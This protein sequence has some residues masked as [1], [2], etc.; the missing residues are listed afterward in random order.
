MEITLVVALI[1]LIGVLVGALINSR[2]TLGRDNRIKRENF[3]SRMCELKSLAGKIENANFPV[4]FAKC[5]V[6]VEKEC[7]LV[8]S[9]ICLRHRKRFV[10]ARKKCAEPQSEN[11]IADPPLPYMEHGVVKSPF[12]RNT[13]QSGRLRIT[14][15]L[16]ELIACAG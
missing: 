16:D 6:A 2:L 7:A 11:D 8:Q 13:Y 1:G 5:Q 3:V 14:G 10:A 4:W 12:Q 15:L 9:A